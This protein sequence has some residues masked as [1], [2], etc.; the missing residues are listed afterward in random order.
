MPLE[1]ALAGSFVPTKTVSLLN[2][3]FQPGYLARRTFYP[4]TQTP[5]MSSRLSGFS[6]AR[7][8]KEEPGVRALDGDCIILASSLVL[9][10]RETLGWECTPDLHP[11]PYSYP[12]HIG[13]ALL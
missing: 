13:W 8:Q 1:E 10:L 9:G 11:Y 3:A 12:Y 2:Q 7:G 6:Q 4:G 5:C